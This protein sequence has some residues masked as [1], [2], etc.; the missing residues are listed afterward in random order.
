MWPHVFEQITDPPVS[1]VEMSSTFPSF[2]QLTD[3]ILNSNHNLHILSLVLFVNLMNRL[4]KLLSSYFI[5]L[6]FGKV[7]LIIGYGFYLQ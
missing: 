2:V 5:P 7:K 1:A 4:S 6:M 3:G